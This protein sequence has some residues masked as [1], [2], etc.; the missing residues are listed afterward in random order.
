MA[1]KGRNR[2]TH[3]VEI[4]FSDEKVTSF[5]GMVLEHRLAQRLGLWRKLHER[6][7]DRSGRY[8]SANAWSRSCS[9]S[10]VETVRSGTGTGD[11]SSSI[12]TK[13]KYDSVVSSRSPVS[14]SSP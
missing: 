6:L 7:P 9:P 12:A 2:K 5:G 10:D 13:T 8:S 14:G 11:R 1:G 4:E 3:T